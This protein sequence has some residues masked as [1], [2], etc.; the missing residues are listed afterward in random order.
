MSKRLVI[1]IA[2]MAAL[3]GCSTSQPIDRQASD[4]LIS[5][6]VEGKLAAN[7]QT[8]NFEIDVDTYDGRVRLAGKVETDAE[9][10]EAERL[11]RATEGVRSVDNRITLGDLGLRENASDGWILAKIKSQL[12]ADPETEAF[13]VDVDVLDGAVTLSG[14]VTAERARDEAQRIAQQTEGVTS[15]RN[16]IEVR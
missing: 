16:L 9:R 4:A 13:N 2:A 7:P 15:V 12:A 10:Q 3:L 1:G 11:A 8:N 6:K 5:S 14:L